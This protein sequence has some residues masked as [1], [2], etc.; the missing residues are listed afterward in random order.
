MTKNK[1]RENKNTLSDNSSDISE[2]KVIIKAIRR[3]P[4]PYKKPNTHNVF[5]Y[6]QDKLQMPNDTSDLRKEFYLR[7]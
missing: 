2:Y 4:A 1:N 3:T 6:H 7:L 5:R